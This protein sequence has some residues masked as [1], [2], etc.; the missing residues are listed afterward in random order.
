MRF[1]LSTFRQLLNFGGIELIFKVLGEDIR[2]EGKLIRF[3][4]L[5]LDKY[6]FLDDPE[7]MIQTLKKSEARIDVFTFLQKPSDPQI[8]Y[9]YLMEM[10]NLAVLSI[11]TFDNWWDHQIRSL[12][13]NRARQAEKR[14]VTFREVPFDDKLVE[15]IWKIY[16][17]SPVRQGKPFTHY[18]KDIDTVRTQACTYLDRSVFVGAFVGDELIGF[19]KLVTDRAQTQANLMNIIAMVRHKEKAPTNALIAQAVKACSERNIPTLVYQ[20]FAYGKKPTDSLGHFKEVNGFQRVDIAR[21]HVPL[22]AVG[23]LALQ[24]ALHRK[25]SDR[26]PE[27]LVSRFRELR[28]SWYSHKF[29]N[30]GESSSP[31][32]NEEE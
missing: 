20:N 30:V 23:R 15:G 11:S 5:D 29:Q 16:N 4:R 7:A 6:E 1:L 8:K 3:G 26:L 28:M 10:D 24:L 14:G 25:L 32:T 27:T 9:N 22:T 19:I 13:R 21:Y 12:P 17:E 2:V 31:R 18:G